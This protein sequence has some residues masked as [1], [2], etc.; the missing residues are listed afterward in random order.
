M[1]GG[2]APTEV[3][4]SGIGLGLQGEQDGR[5]RFLRECLDWPEITPVIAVGGGA[6]FSD[7]EISLELW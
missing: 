4:F 5:L 7:H 6:R 1:D 2:N 3:S